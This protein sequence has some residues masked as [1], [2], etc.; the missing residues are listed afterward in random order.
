[1]LGKG[2]PKRGAE[3]TSTGACLVESLQTR[4]ARDATRTTP[5]VSGAE[6][7]T[8]EGGRVWMPAIHFRFRSADCITTVSARGRLLFTHRYLCTEQQ[9]FTSNIVGA[10]LIRIYDV[11]SQAATYWLS[12]RGP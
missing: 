10:A 2:R 3:G 11:R 7:L 5:Q 6:R 8:R 9:Q 1:M 12:S 4:V